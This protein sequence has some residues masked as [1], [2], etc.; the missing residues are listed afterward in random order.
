MLQ[1]IAGLPPDLAN[2]PPGCAFAPRCFL[3]TDECSA[4]APELFTTD[5]AAERLS[6]STSSGSRRRSA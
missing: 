5:P 4:H 6:T 1:T 3:A 2:L